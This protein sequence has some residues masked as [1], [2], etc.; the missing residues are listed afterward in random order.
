MSSEPIIVESASLVDR[1][2]S[3]HLVVW[4]TL[5]SLHGITD[6]P[7]RETIA[8]DIKGENLKFEQVL[9]EHMPIIE[10]ENTVNSMAKTSACRTYMRE[11]FRITQNYC[12]DTN[13]TNILQKQDWYQ[14]A[15]ILVNCISHNLIFDLDSVNKNRLPTKFNN[16][17]IGTEMHGKHLGKQFTAQLFLELGDAILMF[18]AQNNLGKENE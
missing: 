13:K 16:V 18:A 3:N 7:N 6:M 17:S 4:Y 10:I 11:N 8:M 9:K 1:L 12:T 2:Y 15:R 5:F 14:F